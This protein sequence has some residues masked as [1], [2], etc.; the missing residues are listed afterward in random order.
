[1]KDPSTEQ[2]GPGEPQLNQIAFVSRE[3]RRDEH[4]G[5]GQVWQGAVLRVLAVCVCPCHAL[6]DRSVGISSEGN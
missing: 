2:K 5:C 1:M 3:C 4:I 6:N